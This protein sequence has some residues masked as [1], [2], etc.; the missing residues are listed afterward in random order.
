MTRH[1]LL[2]AR[3]RSPGDCLYILRETII[4]AGGMETGHGQQVIEDM[5]GQIA[6]V[7][8]FIKPL[9]HRHIDIGDGSAERP[10]ILRR[11]GLLQSTDG[12]IRVRHINNDSGICCAGKFDADPS[13]F[14]CSV[15][16]LF[17]MPP[18]EGSSANDT[19]H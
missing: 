1:E 18:K 12:L 9:L 8:L 17:A 15:P 13:S 5:L 11:I 3:W 6:A 7:Q 4:T 14:L 10:G 2:G 16:E 19:G